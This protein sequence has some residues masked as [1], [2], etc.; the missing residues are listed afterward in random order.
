MINKL[1]ISVLLAV[2]LAGPA[3]SAVQWLDSVVA[4]VG[5]DVITRTELEDEMKLIVHELRSRDNTLP[6]RDVLERQV[7]EKMILDALQAQRA[8]ALGIRIDDLTLDKAVEQIAKENKMSLTQFRRALTQE[9][10]D[11]RKFREN[12]RRELAISRLHSRLIDPKITVSDQ[13]VND[14]LERNRSLTDANKQYR[15]R[16]ILIAVPEA[17]TPKQLDSARKKAEEIRKRALAGE[18]FSEL[19]TAYSDGQQALKGGDLGWRA[20]DELPTLFANQVRQ[21]SV[22]GVSEIIHSPSGFHL[23]KVEDIKGGAAK[24]LVEQVR[25]RHILVVPN[26]EQSEKEV[27]A[28]LQ[29]LRVKLLKGEADFATLAKQYSQDPGSAARGGELG[30]AA[31]G[32]YVPAF[33]KTLEQLKPGEISKPFRSRFG[34]HIVQVMDRRTA[35]AS[36]ELL[37]GKARDFLVKQKREEELELWLRQLREESYVDIRLPELKKDEG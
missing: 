16:H 18:R 12:V 27:V 24:P 9:G 32:T 35:P 4:V 6:P 8:E 13:E 2:L 21:L 31:P 19:A 22:G 33:E 10:L 26:E 34:W 23:V 15:L 11:Y 1:G 14:L 30:W 17:A 37:K 36:D 5:Q 7:L 25:A 3:Y 20:G 28:L 29:R